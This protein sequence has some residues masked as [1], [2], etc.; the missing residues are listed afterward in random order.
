M[1]KK[2]N[3]QKARDR[4]FQQMN[5]LLVG[6]IEEN[7]II[8]DVPLSAGPTDYYLTG[9][10]WPKNS[11]VDSSED[12]S[13]TDACMNAEDGNDYKDSAPIFNL[14]RPSSFGVTYTI[15]KDCQEY[16]IMISGAR[17][18][19]TNP[20]D[21]ESSEKTSGEHKQKV[22]TFDWVRE[23]FCYRLVV[24][25][26]AV[27][28]AKVV[29][30]FTD[31][32]GD[33]LEEPLLEMHIKSRV[34]DLG[35]VVTVS[36]VNQ[37]TA[38]PETQRDVNCIFQSQ[39][40][41]QALPSEKSAILPNFKTDRSGDD[42]ELLINR[43]LYSKK[44]EYAVGHAVAAEWS[45]PEDGF[46]SSVWTNWMPKQHISS[47]T[48]KGH[49]TLQLFSEVSESP[50]NS[51]F[52]SCIE[53]KDQ[54]IQQLRI[55]AR[56][57]EDWLEKTFGENI[58]K[59]HHEAFS[60]NQKC[61]HIALDRINA[62]IDT[63]EG[64]DE[65]FKAF[66]F[67]NEVMNNVAS[68]PE[69]KL[70]PRRLIW[71]PFQIAFLLLTIRSIVVEEDN[72]HAIPDREIMDLLWFPTGG[73]KTEAYLALSA[74]VIFYRRIANSKLRTRAHVDIIMRYTLRLLTVQQFQRAAEMICQAE[75]L[76]KQNLQLLGSEPISLGLYVGQAATP[77]K[78][79]DGEF[80]ANKKLQEEIKEQN[81]TS[82]PR[83]LLKCPYCGRALRPIDYRVCEDT[84]SIEI[85]CS[86]KDCQSLNEPLNIYTVDEDIYRV[87]PSMIIGTV[88]K[89]AQLPRKEELS[90]LFGTPDNP[91]PELIIQDELHLIT[92]P[93]GTMMG[94]Y[95]AAI[96]LLST[97][98]YKIPK[99][100]GS[101]ATIGQAKKQVKSL[102]NR[103][104][105]VFPPAGITSGH[106]FFAEEDANEPNRI[107]S[108]IA[109]SGRSPKFTLQAVSASLIAS[110]YCLLEKD[111]FEQSDLDPYWTQ[112]IYFNSLRELG[113]ANVMM[114]DDVRRSVKFYCRRLNCD[115]QRELEQNPIELTSNVSSA[116]IPAALNQLEIS[117]GGNPYEG[118]PIDIVLASNMI[119]V[120][121]DIPRLG[122]MVVNG[123]P[124]MTSEY[125][126]ATSRIG[127]GLPG[128]V[129]SCLNAS[130]PRDISH[131]E[132]F[133]NY[134]QTLYKQVEAASVTPWSSRAR[135]K[136]LHAIFIALVRHLLPY[137]S[138]RFNAADFNPNDCDV[139]K[140]RDWIVERANNSSQNKTIKNEVYSSL[141]QIINDWTHIA[142]LINKSNRKL[143]YWA[144]FDRRNKPNNPYLMRSA[145]DQFEDSKVWRTP[146][147]M[148]EV[149]PTVFYS[150]W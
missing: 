112:L 40:K 75:S 82:T 113:G 68:N 102:F 78:V 94:L 126:Q 140:I 125:I 150:I 122:A 73:G 129:V 26:E 103:D 30:T 116:D 54:I 85:N 33:E 74:F 1:K 15:A 24:E 95:E 107:Y 13:N 137:M 72:E 38:D 36:V 111:E 58:S 60:E 31:V 71:R 115:H 147:S 121:V 22:A 135:D 132:H 44:N 143:E 32:N 41:I 27:N 88:D 124:K 99:I 7:E 118:E 89:M 48:P 144:T 100:I 98:K 63:L 47:V 138:G 76:R 23:P 104:V 117:L 2:N 39:I 119:S 70:I 93:L 77:N 131:F 5:S 65:A 19:R 92:G 141:N 49:S 52:M 17:Y 25:N 67:T 91:P 108:A 66:L 57:Y 20:C 86:N 142:D 148:R 56:K 46:V 97:R 29:S 9:I 149:E 12:D 35:N 110:V 45:E 87:R 11:V 28:K 127:R 79:V 21:L 14:F 96:D 106:S 120:G 134:H 139:I 123:Q 128:L 62:G 4:V 55:F 81:P 61:A 3:K 16:E 109:S 43:M 101:T 136:A 80:S 50:L 42:I 145:E 83:L 59:I 146:N 105:A 69:T 18:V 114:R 51:E 64:N 6:P 90:L 34:F 133:K 84:P 53:N 37:A 130:R 8:K 10:L